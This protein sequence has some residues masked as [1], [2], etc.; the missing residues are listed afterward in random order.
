M[1]FSSVM[2]LVAL[3]CSSGCGLT[4]GKAATTV[5]T[6]LHVTGDIE[7]GVAAS[8]K[9]YKDSLVSQVKA[10]T[11]TPQ[12]SIDKNLAWEAKLARIKQAFHVWKDAQVTASHAI[13]VAN[14]GGKA[15][16]A[17]A[18]NDLAAAAASLTQALND[19]GVHIPSFNPLPAKP[20]AAVLRGVV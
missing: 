9:V 14:N 11:L 17:A 20:S 2:L 15:D 16:Y 13:D 8:D 6:S 19:A 18:M 7:Q 5:A 4:I 10:G 1:R 12:A 3:S